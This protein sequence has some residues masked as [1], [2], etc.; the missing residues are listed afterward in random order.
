L[1]AVFRPLLRGWLARIKTRF[2]WPSGSSTEHM[3]SHEE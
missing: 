1:Q 3:H 2:E